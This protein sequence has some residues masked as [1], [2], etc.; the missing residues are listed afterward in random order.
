MGFGCKWRSKNEIESSTT[1]KLSK[2]FSHKNRRVAKNFFYY[3]SIMFCRIKS[4]KLDVT[5][6]QSSLFA[7]Y[8]ILALLFAWSDLNLYFEFLMLRVSG[9]CA[10]GL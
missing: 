1:Y 6:S 3:K 4:I 5:H 10:I 8:V 9:E 2:Y 7:L